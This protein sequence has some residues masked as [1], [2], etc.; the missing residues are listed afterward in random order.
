MADVTLQ[1]ITVIGHDR[2]GIIAETTRVL[3]DLG[4]EWAH[5]DVPVAHALTP[6]SAAFLPRDLDAAVDQ[7]GP[8]GI[9][10]AS[11][12]PELPLK[13]VMAGGTRVRTF[14]VDEDPSVAFDGTVVVLVGLAVL[15]LWIPI[16]ERMGIGTVANAIVIGLAA[17]GLPHD[18][19][20]KAIGESRSSRIVMVSGRGL[21][22]HVGDQP[23]LP[24][25]ARPARHG[26]DVG[27]PRVGG[28]DGVDLP[29]LHPKAADL[30]LGV[31]PAVV[32]D[33][34]AGQVPGRVAGA[35]HPGAGRP[36]RV[37]HHL[38]RGQPRV[39]EVAARYARA[40]GVE[41]AGHPHRDG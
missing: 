34:A 33:L 31:D 32:F 27:H 17:A 1:A 14:R 41:L 16:R 24:R 37:G 23:G 2:P 10:S 28:E 25:P 5:P 21:A 8:D 36:P 6:G 39:G 35:V 11:L 30:D 26:G 19:R 29:Q 12:V 7:L 40:G 4:L 3:A 18:Q 13:R 22:D 38:G 20:A 15:L 9:A